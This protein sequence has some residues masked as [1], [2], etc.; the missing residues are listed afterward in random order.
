MGL[1]GILIRRSFDLVFGWP[2]SNRN[3]VL[4]FGEVLKIL[5]TKHSGLWCKIFGLLWLCFG[6]KNCSLPPDVYSHC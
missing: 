5:L 3:A 1:W 2:V 6:K 4:A